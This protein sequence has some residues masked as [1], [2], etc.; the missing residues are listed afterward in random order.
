[1]VRF[2]VVLAVVAVASCSSA[3]DEVSIVDPNPSR[4]DEVREFI[5]E[6]E[7]RWEE[8]DVEWLVE[9]MHPVTFRFWTPQECSETLSFKR[10]FDDE[11]LQDLGEVTYFPEFYIDYGEGRRADLAE[12]YRTEVFELGPEGSEESMVTVAFVGEDPKWFG[13]CDIPPVP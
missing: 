11:T 7:Q 9:R 10:P 12:V 1:M 2:L 6:N 4:E 5:W 3:R 8:G 13:N